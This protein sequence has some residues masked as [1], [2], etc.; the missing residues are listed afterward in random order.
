MLLV[1]NGVFTMLM[2]F[3]VLSAAQRTPIHRPPKFQWGEGQSLDLDKSL[4]DYNN[5]STGDRTAILNALA[6][7]FED[8][9][10]PSPMERAERTL[11]NFFD[12]NGDGGILSQSPS[13]LALIFAVRLIV[14]CMFFKRPA[15]TTE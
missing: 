2:L 5:I 4:A 6:R 13:L 1:K 9:P 7:K 3:V 8:Y 10:P 11:V 15:R 12:L 14:R